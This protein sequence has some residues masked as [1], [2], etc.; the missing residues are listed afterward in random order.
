MNLHNKTDWQ[1]ALMNAVTEP[2]ELLT[3]LEFDDELLDAANKA[4]KHFPLKVPHSFIARME[5]KNIND[6]LLQQVLP[7]GAELENI[8]G[9]SAD[10][11]QETKVNPVKGLLH[12]YHGRVL[13]TYVATCA[14]NCRY[15]FRR[16]FPY[17][18][19]NPGSSGWN[20]ALDYISH[21]A[22]IKEVILSGGDPLVAND[23]H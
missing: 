7:I 4:A 17:K 11:L 16:E 19:N 20:D 10:P 14:V 3:L 2:K 6:P 13:L 5:K 22:S 8:A 9:F 18:K 23:N 15:C 12:K 1:T 21:N